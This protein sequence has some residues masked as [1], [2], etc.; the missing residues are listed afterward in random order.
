MGIKT[1]GF[2]SDQIHKLPL[3]TYPW[4]SYLTCVLVSLPEKKKN[5]DNNY[6]HLQGYKWVQECALNQTIYNFDCKRF[7]QLVFR[8]EEERQAAL[9]MPSGCIVRIHTMSFYLVFIPSL[10][11]VHSS[12]WSGWLAQAVRRCLWPQNTHSEMNWPIWE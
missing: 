8:Q 7:I 2:E 5:G 6:T 10:N 1:V 3:A 9:R 4:A 12:L 11:S